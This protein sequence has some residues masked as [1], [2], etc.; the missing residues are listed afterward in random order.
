M[1]TYSNAFEVGAALPKWLPRCRA[2]GRCGGPRCPRRPLGAVRADALRA[3][4]SDVAGELL[5]VRLQGVVAHAVELV[6][7]EALELVR[8]VE[9][10]QLVSVEALQLVGVE[11]L[12]LV[13]V[14]ALQ[15]RIRVH[16]VELS[17]RIEAAE[18]VVREAGERVRLTQQTRALER[19]RRRVEHRRRLPSAGNE[20][21]HP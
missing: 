7:V 3:G 12:Q 4:C 15:L 19:G 8:S 14:E 16:S 5:A 20:G 13:G 18:L 11:A 1:A 9:A 21:G 10:L 17:V 2:R 6:G